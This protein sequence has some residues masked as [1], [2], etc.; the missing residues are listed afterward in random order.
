MVKAFGKFQK[1]KAVHIQASAYPQVEN[2]IKIGL[3]F[4]L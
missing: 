2:G 1:P 3:D 4:P